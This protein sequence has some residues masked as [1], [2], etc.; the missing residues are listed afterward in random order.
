MEII[1]LEDKYFDS[2]CN[3]VHNTI[4]TT[5]PKYYSRGAV[6]LFHK[7]H[8][9]EELLK[10]ISYETVFLCKIDN[11]I[12]G[13]GTVFNDEIKRFFILPEYQ[14]KG[15][16]KILLEKMEKE[17]IKNYDTAKLAASLCSY[18]FYRKYLF[19]EICYKILPTE[20]DGGLCYFEMEKYYNREYEINF[21]GKRFTTYNNSSN[22]EVNNE[23]VFNYHQK[24]NNIW[25]D[26]SGGSIVNGYLL[27]S[28]N[29]NG[30]LEFN[31]MHKN[32]ENIIRTGKCNSKPEKMDNGR[33]KM[34]EKWEWTN[35]DKSKGESI[36][37]E[38]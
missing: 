25:A 15:Y 3:V 28:T 4:E 23:T 29:K 32:T 20:D 16:G 7:Y 24:G 11:D 33:I 35:G 18:N 37:I 10:K 9:K 1:K 26:Y 2:F 6:D 17:I 38:I 5:Y 30:E 31:Y 13:T 8:S 36:I 14:G 12:I 22:G 27:G 21:N 34:N 19:E